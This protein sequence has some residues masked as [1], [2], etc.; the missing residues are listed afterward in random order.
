MVT[1]SLPVALEG[2]AHRFDVLLFPPA[3]AEWTAGTRLPTSPLPLKG[4]RLIG[5]VGFNAI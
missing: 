1:R 2:A 4:D 3:E 5:L